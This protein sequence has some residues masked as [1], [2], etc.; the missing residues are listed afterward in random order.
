[1]DI[2]KISTSIRSVILGIFLASF[3]LSSL[4][5]QDRFITRTGSITFESSVP[6]FEEVKATNEKVTAVLTPS[7]DIACALNMKG[8]RFKIRLMEEHFNENYIESEKFPKASFRG[9]IKDFSIEQLGEE[10]KTF[11]VSGTLT[12]RNQPEE[13]TTQ[14]SLKKEGN[15]IIFTTNFTTKPE[16]FDI[17]IPSIVRKKIAEDVDISATF[18]FAIKE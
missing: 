12:I 1:M 9:K 10:P 8:F 13:I 14:C 16:T 18:H 7:G 6:S 2:L 17:A 3:A 11:T 4:H 5:A 15:K